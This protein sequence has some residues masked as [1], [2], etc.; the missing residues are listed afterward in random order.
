MRIAPTAQHISY[1]QSLEP[2]GKDKS[3][4]VR[5][6][7]PRAPAG[8][9]TPAASR[10]NSHRPAPSA[11][12]RPSWWLRMLHAIFTVWVFASS[13]AALVVS[14]ETTAGGSIDNVVE[15]GAIESLTRA[16]EERVAATADEPSLAPAEDMEFA[17]RWLSFLSEIRSFFEEILATFR[18]TDADWKSTAGEAGVTATD[19]TAP[20]SS[21]L[22]P[23]RTFDRE[24]EALQERTALSELSSFYLIGFG[25]ISLL[26]LALIT[27]GRV[28]LE[29][30]FREYQQVVFDAVLERAPLAIMEKKTPLKGDP[31]PLTEKTKTPIT[32]PDPR[33]RVMALAKACRS[34]AQGPEAPLGPWNVAVATTIGPVREQ[35][36]DWGLAFTIKDRSRNPHRTTVQALV[37]A[38]GCG[39]LPHGQKAAETAVLAAAGS[40]IRSYSNP[41]PILSQSLEH[42]A[43]RAM[44]AAASKLAVVGQ[45]LG[46]ANGLRSTLILVLGDTRSFAY[47]Y[48]GD[49][50]GAVIRH[51]SLVEFLKPQKGDALNVLAASLGPTVE[52]EPISG[53]IK[54]RCG[55][56]LVAGTDGVF[57]R[58]ATSIYSDLLRS[59]VEREGDLQGL[60]ENVV[61]AL[62]DVKDEAGFIFDDN[63]T[64]GLMGTGETPQLD[65]TTSSNSP[66]TEPILQV[67]S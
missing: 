55:D 11:R 49:G 64:I 54:R 41:K 48:I 53:T 29:R 14:Q 24:L 59:A 21:D 43:C 12:R 18:H 23:K 25:T 19:G 37:I 57:D 62:S 60:A 36:Q 13:T 15:K 9:R 45:E 20:A 32:L 31:C 17:S 22:Y 35:N 61:H 8:R 58:V 7:A 40:I 30:R 52:G 39:G 67:T 56:L 10:T 27:V 51:D 6:V 66:V 1:I 63:L 33:D 5:A 42:I 16:S 44:S 46:V 47:C 28:Y 26:M 65:R 2:A 34:L 50:G 38:D 4:P 3:A